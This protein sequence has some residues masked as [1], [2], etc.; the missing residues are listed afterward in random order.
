MADRDG[1]YASRVF[2]FCVGILLAAM[3]LWGAVAIISSIW[4]ALCIG[5]LVIGIIGG[6]VWISVARFRRW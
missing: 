6:V 4:L 5:V 3:A 1:R 2:D